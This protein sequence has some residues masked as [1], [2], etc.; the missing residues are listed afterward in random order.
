MGTRIRQVTLDVQMYLGFTFLFFAGEHYDLKVG[1]A[2]KGIIQ[3]DY[4]HN[5]TV[6]KSPYAKVT[7]IN[8][9]GLMEAVTK[10]NVLIQQDVS[11]PPFT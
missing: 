9:F 6:Y 1:A 2:S 8:L 11:R 5:A 3:R 7:K 4:Q 10:P